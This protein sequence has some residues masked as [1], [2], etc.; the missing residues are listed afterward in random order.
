MIIHL[1][2]RIRHCLLCEFGKDWIV[3]EAFKNI[4]TMYGDALTACTYQLWFQ[5]FKNVDCQASSDPLSGR[6]STLYE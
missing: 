2:Q 5:R 4:L 6:R 3:I 1:K